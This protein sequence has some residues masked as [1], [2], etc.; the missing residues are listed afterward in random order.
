MASKRHLQSADTVVVNKLPRPDPAA[1]FLP[2]KIPGT[3]SPV[4]QPGSENHFNYKGFYFAC[5]L[6]SP[7]SPAAGWSPAPAYLPYGPGALS[8]PVPAEGPLLGFLPYPPG[9]P[10]SRLQ[11][12]NTHKC[13]DSLSQEQLMARKKLDSPRC[14]LPVKK[15]MVVKK[16][17]PLAPK[18][19]YGAPASFLAPRM[20]LLLGTQ[21]ESLQQRP[22]E[23]NWALPPTTHPLHPAEPHKR[24]PCSDHRLQLLPSSQ[25]LP[26]KEQLGSRVSL[27]HCCVTFDKYRAPPSTLFV[28]ASRPSAQS[29]KVPEVPS[30]SL[31]SW[32]KL[33]APDASPV[34]RDRTAMCYPAPPYPLSPHRAG[35][36]CHPPAPTVGEPSALP[37][38][39]YVGSREPFPST[40]LKPQVPRSY[41]PSPLEPYVQGTGAASLGVVLRDAEP[42]RDAELP[43]NTGYP[44]FAVS[45]GDASMFHASFPSM[46]LGCEQHGADSPQWRTAPR[47]S[48]AFQPV[49]TSEKL[50]GGSGGLAETFPQ[51][52]GNW[53]KPRQGVEEPLY[54]G[55]RNISLVPQDTPHG[56]PGEGNACNI[57]DP[58]KELIHPSPSVT[59]TQGLEDLRDTKALSSSPPMPVIH[60]VFSLAPY[61]E[62]LE[63][64]KSSDPIL[65]CKKHLWEDSSPQNTGRRN[66][67]LVPQ[68]TPHGGPGEGNAC[69]IK[70]PAKELIH[71]S[72]SVTPTQGLEDLRD[73]KALS[74]S[75][76]MPVIHNV[77]SLAPYQEFL[78]RA[79]SSDPILICK[80]HL[81]EDSSP[82]N[83]GG[84]QEPAALKDTS[85]V[86]SP[87]SG[88]A[89]VQSQGENCYR[90]SPKTPKSLPQELDSQEGSPDKVGTEELHPEDKVLDLSFKKRLVEAGDTQRPS[91]CAE[92]TVE[93][94]VK[95]EK[96]AA[97]GKVGLGEGA[98]PWMPEADSGDRS[99]FQSSVTFMF[100]K[101][102]LLPSLLPSTEPPRQDGSPQAP[103]PSPPSSTPTPAHPAPS[104]SCTPLLPPP[105]PQ[106]SIILGPNPPQTLLHK[107]PSTPG[108]EKVSVA[109]QAG[110]SPT[111]SH[112][113]QYFTTLHT[114]LCDTISE[115][116]S[117]SSPELLWQWLEKADLAG[118]LPK[119]LPK[120]KNG[121]KAPNPQKPSK[122][123]EIWLAFQ[124]VAELL[125]KLLSE[126]HSF[127]LA[128][129]FPHVVRA[130]AIFIPIHMVKEKLFPKLP[131]SFVDQVLQKHKVELRP[132]TLSEEKHLRDLELKSCTSR[133]LKL[134]ALKQLPEIYPDLLNLHWLNSIWQQLGR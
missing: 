8:Q 101:Y 37:G 25:V 74:S 77:F 99:S 55:R 80:K 17:A 113:G 133:M 107:A 30:L 10:G 76:P 126:L 102:K 20:A 96:E 78:E 72:P 128:C 69:N 79:K 125:S 90:S 83:T 24:S 44:G 84:N 61:Q 105:G 1:A 3:S 117:R 16:A 110:G 41:F 92:G 63:R 121:S 5:P 89:A 88:S 48:S 38:F 119:S 54:P 52:G 75:P 35:P 130:G 15:P 39:G 67:S 29:Q 134:L 7:E 120:P 115:S 14:P 100:Q 95:E 47:H 66:I 45:L 43:R 22:G 98:Q 64:A 60:N 12:P 59:P 114:L 56:G 50:S 68:D 106:L 87:R 71:P 86:S 82:Q 112:S 11:P 109:R 36:L 31:D 2:S 13:K 127:M 28:E 122:G 104:P 4:P 42:P 21:A 62:F 34:T 129:P 51:R 81:W 57:K 131:G 111:R 18:P 65:I 9:S 103:Q 32:P 73:T 33:Q 6:Q 70:D 91:G 124:D 93:R 27:P 132:T 49:C 53:E 123:K 40:Y 97:K 26:S 118:E 94:E 85:V 116:V 19:V 108:E 23:V 46:E 58:A